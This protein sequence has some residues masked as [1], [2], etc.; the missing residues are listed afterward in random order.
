MSERYIGVDVGGTSTKLVLFEAPATVHERRALPSR[1][2]SGDEFVA[3]V[4]AVLQ[5]WLASDAGAAVSAVG[6]GVAGLIDRGGGRLLRAPNLEMLEGFAL[7]P[8]LRAATGLRVEID[9][10]ANAAGL[11][12]ATLGAAV[13]CTSAVC[14]TVGTGVGGAIVQE[15]RLW[16]G[17]AGMAGEIGRLLLDDDAPSYLEDEVG[18]AA[19][20]RRYRE[21]DGATVDDIDA[22]EV[23]RRAD[24]GDEA[25]QQALADCGRRL[26]VGLAV[27]VNLLNPERIVIGGGIAGAGKWFLD[28]AR[29]EGE[30]RAWPLAWEQ[31]EIVAAQLGADAGAIGA[32][33]LCRP[34]AR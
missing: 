11:A 23:A 29:R 18:A 16:R 17:H 5:P 28:P 27:L 26:G 3:S 13:G 14:L 9:N 25:A 12:E 19:V 1:W 24:Q 31:C 6:L 33:L 2:S 4:I 32:A 10:D 7:V 22:A 20:V 8:A 15:G 34:A 30:R 21:G